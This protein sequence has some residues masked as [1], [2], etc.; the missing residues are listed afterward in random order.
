[1]R[2]IVLFLL[3][4]L[5]T[6]FAVS[7]PSIERRATVELIAER[8]AVQPG[9][10]F[11]AA[12]DMQMV[13][14]WHVYWRNP[15]DVG[16]PPA[17]DQWLTGEAMAG[18][19]IW[20]IPHELPVV[21]GKIMDYGFKERLIL[22][23]PVTV[24]EDAAGLVS[25]SGTLAY[26][27]C[28]DVCIQETADFRLAL[29]VASEA[30]IEETNGAL[31]ASWIA[32]TA[33]PLNGSARLTEIGDTW[34]LSLAAPELTLIDR[35]L[36]F[37]PYGEEIVHSAEQRLSFGDDGASLALTPFAGESFPAQI[38]GVI[39]SETLQ[40][41][42]RGYEITATA[43]PALPNTSGVVAPVVAD[44]TRV[45]LL[46][47]IGLALLGGLVLNLM[48][49]VLP[50]LAIKAVGFVHAA[51]AGNASELR[52]H[53]LFYSLGV[54]L[55]FLGIAAT[56]VILRASGE[57]LSIGFQLQYPLG[58]AALALL[59]FAIGLWLLG[60]FELGTSVQ[61]VGSGLANRDGSVGAFFTGVLA[62]MV[63][64]PCIGP[65]LGVALGAV[66][67]EPAVIVFLV[68]GLVG[69][70]LALPF[71]ILSFLPD[72]QRFLPKPGA[73]MD[74]LKQLFAFPMF[75]TAIWLLSV[76]GDQAGV[77]AVVWT[78]T[79][80]ATIAFGLW[81][82]NK[83]S[84]RSNIII[85]GIAAIALLAGVALPLR[86]GLSKDFSDRA[87]LVSDRRDA[88]EKWS[89]QRLDELM[90]EGRGALVDFTASWCATC[91]LNKITTLQTEEIQSAL[92]A[93]NIVFMVADFTNGDDLIAAE[94]KKRGRPG[95]PMYLLYLP[96][97]AE[98]KILPQILSRDL[99][100]REIGAV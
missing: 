53:G 5:G 41:D 69:F 55:S 50:V 94:L 21:P 62:A 95:V 19:F 60:V 75:L 87:V 15:G 52:K 33:E 4:L 40:G 82:L 64:A 9:E 45:S 67:S 3:M 36:R 2:A 78:T 42:R 17:V 76:L 96:G 38:K 91:Q 98:P 14:G 20:P 66:I 46:P 7:Q 99:I 37:F 81:L 27:I 72:L 49:C 47:I 58:V 80:A 8:K 85:R 48:P 89:P 90:L 56:F 68:F 70:G 84:G 23:F 74:T 63:G 86:A 79:G 12:F 61:G 39:V 25:L 54:V 57:F 24:P 35:D 26:L 18:D 97:S 13:D 31:I 28:E 92:S 65:F 77:G 30:R 6:Q 16:L 73:W 43:G 32:K 88:A 59:M 1:M 10:T 22:P 29:P 34:T 100:L 93:N 71:L 83:A 51:A 11:F 44:L